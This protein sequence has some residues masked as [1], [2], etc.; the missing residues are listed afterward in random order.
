MRRR[1]EEDNN[2]NK[3][4]SEHIRIRQNDHYNFLISF[5]KNHIYVC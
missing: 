3:E 2:C 1:N 5:G 4:K